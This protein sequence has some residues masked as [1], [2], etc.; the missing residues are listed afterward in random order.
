[1]PDLRIIKEGN[2]DYFKKFFKYPENWLESY[3]VPY[4][5]EVSDEMIDEVITTCCEHD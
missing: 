2:L 1:M 5:E 3:E 4:G